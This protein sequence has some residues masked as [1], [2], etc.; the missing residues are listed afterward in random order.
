MNEKLHYNVIAR[1][2]A[3]SADNS[4]QKNESDASAASKSATAST[5]TQTAASSSATNNASSPQ[6]Q[7]QAAATPA[8]NDNKQQS[9][10]TSQDLL[11]RL[12]QQ[13]Q[14]SH[15]LDSK[16]IADT[17]NNFKA[18]S[19]EFAKGLP[20]ATLSITMKIL[21]AIASGTWKVIKQ[22][23][24]LITWWDKIV[25]VTKREA[26]H[27]WNG[28]KLLVAD[29]RYASRLV[30]KVTQGYSLSRRE[31]FMVSTLLFSLFAAK[32]FLQAFTNTTTGCFFSLLF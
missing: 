23:S 31:R 2:Y 19:V 8:A 7:Q 17:L 26:H 1:Q 5:S 18:K 25:Q 22:P 15:L 21:K 24:I 12:T 28:S 6:Q 32:L 11:K 4:S 29:I 30:R 27:Y 9:G 14:T 10:N 13:S 16:S 3:V 20:A